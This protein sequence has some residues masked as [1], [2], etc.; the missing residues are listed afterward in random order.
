MHNVQNSSQ[1]ERHGADTAYGSQDYN[2]EVFHIH[3]TTTDTALYK[4][5]PCFT[6]DPYMCTLQVGNSP[7]VMVVNTGAS[8]SIVSEHSHKELCTRESLTLE[9]EDLPK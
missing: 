2:G 9:T 5:R 6:V 7:L 3:Q 4:S 8:L 1:P